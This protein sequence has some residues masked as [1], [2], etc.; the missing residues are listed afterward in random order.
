SEILGYDL[1]DLCFNGPAER[2]DST[3]HSQPA[4]YV[5]S[6]A[7]L[8]RLKETSPETVERCEFAAG[9]SLGEYTALVFAGALDWE[10][11]LRLVRERGEAMQAA[12]DQSPSGMVSILG[13]D[14]EKVERLCD[15]ARDGGEL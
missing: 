4:L 3:V 15:E 8:E 11:G 1:G 10:N 13:L 14:Q 6:L 2:L 9:L 12:A 5:C 7:A